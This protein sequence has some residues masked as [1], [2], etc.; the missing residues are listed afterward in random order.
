MNT[1]EL[2]IKPIV[3]HCIPSDSVLCQESSEVEK[4][5]WDAFVR[6]E[7]EKLDSLIVHGAEVRE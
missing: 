4:A 6:R 3:V 2:V 1:I 7:A 5:C